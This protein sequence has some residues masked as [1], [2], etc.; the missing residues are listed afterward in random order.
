MQCRNSKSTAVT[1]L[2][3]CLYIYIY[4]KRVAVRVLADF[5]SRYKFYKERDK[6][7]EMERE[8]ARSPPGPAA[9]ILDV[10]IFYI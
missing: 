1:F 2:T 4:S 10:I 6:G 3:K 7:R 9:P 8:K 5:L